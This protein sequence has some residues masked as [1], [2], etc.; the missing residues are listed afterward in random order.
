MEI[1]ICGCC[2]KQYPSIHKNTHHKQPRSL[3]GKDNLDNLIELCPHCHDGL[4]AIAHKLLSKYSNQVQ[5][6]D[7]LSLM[8]PDNKKAQNIC[9][10]LALKVR[11]AT[12]HDR[13]NG[14]D[15]NQLVMISTNIRKQYKSMIAQR[16]SEMNTSQEDYFRNLIIMDISKRFN[17]N[18]TPVDEN[19]IISH[20]KK[21]K[22]RK[23]NT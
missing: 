7:A 1:F 14:S 11:N 19:R 13:E 4:H 16:A 8:F 20:I 21:N 10:D 6:T 9:L 22:K 18:I 23:S 3:G 2:S 15:P 12:I 17:L 5:I